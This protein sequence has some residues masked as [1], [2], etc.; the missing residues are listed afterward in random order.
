M[1]YAIGDIHG[2][3]NLLV[4]LY[5]KIMYNI[6]Q[7]KDDTNTII[8]LGDYIDRGHAS[9]K[10]IDF[11]RNLKDSDNIKH[12]FL[13]GNHET[14]FLNALENPDEK[15]EVAFWV[16]NGGEA[17][18]NETGM[19]FWEFYKLYDWQSIKKWMIDTLKLYHETD[20]YVFLHGGLDIRRKIYSQTPDYVLWARHTIENHYKDYYKM[21]IHGH[22][23][24]SNPYIDENRICIDTS[25]HPTQKILTSI[26]L[27]NN[28][29]LKPKFLTSKRP[30]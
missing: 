27:D 19:D 13:W 10:V 3:Y 14:M 30:L 26:A 8:F 25:Y 17:V 29:K 21:V 2:E 20:Y 4:D 1:I 7:S 15:L 11:L 22:T 9:L 18:L 5:S 6:Q 28:K 16:R 24:Y 23:S 12:V